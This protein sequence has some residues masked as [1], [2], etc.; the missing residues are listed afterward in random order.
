MQRSQAPDDSKPF[1]AWN[2]PYCSYPFP[3]VM[4]LMEGQEH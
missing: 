4:Y 2:T 1:F 3:L